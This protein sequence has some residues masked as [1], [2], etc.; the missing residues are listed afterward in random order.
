[1]NSPAPHESSPVPDVDGG[2]ALSGDRGQGRR[3]KRRAI[4]YFAWSLFGLSVV[5]FAAGA[6][7]LVFTRFAQGRADVWGI[8]DSLLVDASFLAF[9][10]VGALLASR[11]PWNPI[12]WL[13]LADGLL[14]MLAIIADYY[15]Q[16][17]RV[18]PGV[19]PFPLAVVSLNEW[20][21]VPA[22]GLFGIFLLLSFPD[23]KLPSRRWRP[24]A[25]LSGAVMVLLTFGIMLAPGSLESLG[26]E[27]NPFGIGSQPW[28]GVAAM[29][30]LPLLPLCMFASAVSLVMRYRRSGGEVRRQIKWVALAAAFMGALYLS[31]MTFGIAS[32]FFSGNSGYVAPSWLEGV[33]I[34]SFAGVP[35]SV[36]FA[37][38]KY[39]LY[40]IEIIVNR[41]LVY[42]ALTISLAAMYFGSVVSLQYAFRA[43]TGEDSQL[44]VVASTLA[45]A[46][47][48]V[49][50]RRRVQ[51]FID[52]RFYRR[53]YDA[54]QVLEVFSHRL[55]NETNL[56][57]LS[58]DLNRVARETVQPTHASVWLRTPSGVRERSR[59]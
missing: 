49:P 26:G 53:K 48:F 39:R 33:M 21:W 2:V 1:M 58:E 23:G 8:A 50:L 17:E 40:D 6:A 41:A 12:G 57:A 31:L 11:R 38:M 22:I 43:V 51:A 28:L 7:L 45:I 29:G 36:G 35:I 44:A 3:M 4:S 24:L 25:W 16:Y 54:R 10:V 20:I 9:P 30:I 56:D 32:T 52:R 19:L 14:W 15:G 5:M 27:R 47:L 37:V 18:E 55:R 59:G 46:A 42:G 13:L 34:L